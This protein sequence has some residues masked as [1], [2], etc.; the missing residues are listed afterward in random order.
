M[1]YATAE[2]MQYALGAKVLRVI[3]DF[4]GDLQADDPNINRAIAEA[5]SLA[6]SYIDG[7]LPDG[8]DVPAALRRAVVDIAAYYLRAG[9]DRQTESSQAAY[10]AAI[11]WL[12]TIASGKAT[13][14]PDAGD[15]SSPVGLDPGD[16]ESEGLERVWSRASARGVF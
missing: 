4:S 9:R 6:D 12:K 8:T 5:S 11:E 14:L 3:G 1:P 15:P 10:D 13:I 16:A 2:D 7:P